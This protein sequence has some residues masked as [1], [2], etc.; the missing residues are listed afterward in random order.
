MPHNCLCTE[1]DGVGEMSKS[2][3]CMLWSPMLYLV[4]V[5]VYKL[6]SKRA[7]TLKP[8]YS[9]HQGHA[10]FGNAIGSLP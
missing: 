3:R 6:C 5:L 7:S 2:N 9:H 10:K 4:D 1:P 8:D